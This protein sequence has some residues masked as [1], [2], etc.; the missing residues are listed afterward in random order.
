M[1]AR[2]LG[3][4]AIVTAA[5]VLTLGVTAPVSWARPEVQVN[6]EVSAVPSALQPADLP[7]VRETPVDPRLLELP[8]S[9]TGG[10]MT[11]VVHVVRDP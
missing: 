4:S 2:L 6:T 8:N 5:S 1:L 11:I 3:F 7:P 10:T 9:G